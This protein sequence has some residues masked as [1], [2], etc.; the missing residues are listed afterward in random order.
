[1][2]SIL[3]SFPKPPTWSAVGHCERNTGI[4]LINGPDL[5]GKGTGP[6]LATVYGIVKQHGGNISV[7]SEPGRGTTFRICLPAMEG[8]AADETAPR[9]SP[10]ADRGTETLMVAEDNDMVRNLAVSILGRLGYTVLVAS[11]GAECLRLLGEHKGPL[12][13][14]LT[15]VVM[16]EM[17]G[18][19]LFEQVAARFPDVK[20]LYMSGHTENVIAHRGVLDEGVNFIQKP[21]S[22]QGLAAKV[23]KVLEE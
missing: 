14:L 4:E 21:F 11:S 9:Q 10:V 3:N 17:N 5:K 1:M 23:R 2:V 20:V 16:P 13:P 8:A 18:K 15:D 12:D 22:M 19:A 7:Y 6:G